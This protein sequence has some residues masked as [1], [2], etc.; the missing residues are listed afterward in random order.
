MDTLRFEPRP[1][2]QRLL[3]IVRLLPYKRVDLVVTACNRL[4]VGLDVVGD[5]PL[6][7]ELRELA[8]PT[9]SFHGAVSDE[10]LLEMTEACSAVCMPGVEDFGI[11]ALEGNAAG[12]PPLAFAAGGALETIDG[13]NG[14]LFTAPTVKSVTDAIRRLDAIS[15]DPLELAAAAERFSVERF[16]NSLHAKIT[17]AVERH[18]DGECRPPP[19]A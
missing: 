6:R 7:R 13:V 12:K 8:G 1:R 3:A 10:A 15:A 17:E 11:V 5:G 16:R 2:G 18:R 4:G 19:R 9:V 14:V